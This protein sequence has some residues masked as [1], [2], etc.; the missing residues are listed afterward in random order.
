MSHDELLALLARA[1]AVLGHY[2]FEGEDA[3]VRDDIAEICMAIDD[4]LPDET[5]VPVKRVTLERSAA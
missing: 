5:R 2:L 1:R 3:P 4:A